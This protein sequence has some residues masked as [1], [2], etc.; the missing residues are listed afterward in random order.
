MSASSR[1]GLPHCGQQVCPDKTAPSR[2]QDL[3]SPPGSSH[4]FLNQPYPF[5]FNTFKPSPG[6]L[7]PAASMS[8]STMTLDQVPKAKAAL[9]SHRL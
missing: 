2:H 9:P 4:H 7:S 8:A 3:F 6:G 1:T 5:A